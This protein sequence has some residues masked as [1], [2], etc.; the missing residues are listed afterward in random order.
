MKQKSMIKNHLSN[1]KTIVKNIVNHHPALNII[2][3]FIICSI[4]LSACTQVIVIPK[5]YFILE[6]KSIFE[7]LSLVQQNPYSFVVRVTDA[8]ISSTYNR[9][10]MII[11]TSENQIEYDYDNLWADRLPNAI[12]NLVFQRI[13]RYRMFTRVIRDYQQQ[14]KYD[15]NINVNAI[16]FLNYGSV[17]GAHLNID[18]LLRRT[19]DNVVVFQHSSQKHKALLNEDMDMFVQSINDM[20]ME[21][22]DLFVKT[23]Q[24]KMNTIEKMDS[25][26]N[27]IV[28]NTKD[29]L[30]D[31]LKVALR[32]QIPED[33]Q[34]SNKGRLFVPAK[35]DP[36]NE[37]LFSI[38]YEDGTPYA[39]FQMGEDVPLDPGNYK[40][41]LGNGTMSQ[42]VVEEIT[43]YPRYKTV[44]DADIGWLTINI[45]DDSRNQLD[46]RYEIFDMSNAESY[47]FGYGIKE[48]VGQQLETW[49]LRPGYYKIVLNGMPFNT[50][51]D[52]TTVE[53]KKGSLEQITIVVDE[54]TNKLI[55][56]GKLIQED[57]DRGSGKIKVSVLNH[58]NANVNMKND[59]DKN[60]NNYSLTF[61]EQL[62]AKL[63]YDNYP[64]HYTSKGLLEIG[65][66]DESDTKLK[67]SSDNFDIKNTFVYYFYKNFGLYSRA[68]M[69]THLFDEFIH[70]KENRKYKTINKNGVETLYNTDKFKTKE[71][72]YPIV[73]KEGA[74]LNYRVLNKNRASL[75]LRIGIGMRQ[76]IN[77]NVY[78]YAN[79][80]D[81]GYEVYEEIPS[82]YKKGT[83]I[84]SNGN[85]QIFSNLNYT[86]N[87]DILIPFDSDDNETFEWENILNLRMF[88]YISWDY[89]INFSYNK[90]IQDHVVMD[91]SLYLRLTYIFV[92]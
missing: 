47:G 22:T 69:N 6:Y 12:S 17:F 14:A 30:T 8:E 92:R 49:I 63:V 40:I 68:D 59:V 76:D 34:I 41:L 64:Y 87:A 33:E 4:V 61:I 10:Q 16:E 35:T 53:V 27:I 46:L 1:Q 66:T 60:K 65:V 20:I 50:Y 81:N 73:F 85:F 37:P 67:I 3:F 29:I 89:R 74:G 43:I 19:K 48:G 62:D 72:F 84:S 83:E 11:R 86:T 54:T 82:V 26:S 9:R 7:D 42:K 80:Q 36:E 25:A 44:L 90:S 21:E 24:I 15:I 88:K 77:K 55:G 58:L 31:S 51:S 13:S 79:K 5:R 45:I 38:E 78:S 39:S 91:H 56:A 57:I 70:T 18:F 2:L 32:I 71:R 28:Y 23:L 75:N 52:F